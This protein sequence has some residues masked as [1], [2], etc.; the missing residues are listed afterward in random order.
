MDSLIAASR[1][2]F[3]F[4]LATRNRGDFDGLGI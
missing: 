2:A 3:D 1:L 4:A